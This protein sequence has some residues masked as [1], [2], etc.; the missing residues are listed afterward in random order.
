MIWILDPI[1]FFM[2]S[3]LV[4]DRNDF[5]IKAHSKPTVTFNKPRGSFKTMCALIWV[6]DL[7]LFHDS[8]FFCGG[9]Y[10]F[11]IKAYCKGVG[12]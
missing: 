2:A 7:I 11:A 5:A 8:T 1:V 10:H 6:L 9:P 3:F 4:G 12:I